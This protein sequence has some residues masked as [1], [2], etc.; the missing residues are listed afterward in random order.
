MVRTVLGGQALD[1]SGLARRAERERQRVRASRASRS[2]GY[3]A[4]MDP[5]RGNSGFTRSIVLKR[6]LA[7]ADVLR[8]ARGD[9]EPA[10]APTVDAGGARPEPGRHRA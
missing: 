2:T 6:G 4:Q 9:A 10:A 8:N 1:R 3:V 5:E 7:S